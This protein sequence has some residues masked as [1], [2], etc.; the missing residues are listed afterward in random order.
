MTALLV[1]KRLRRA[2]CS[3]DKLAMPGGL[4]VYIEEPN[5][6]ALTGDSV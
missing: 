1:V 3:R 5:R 6:F 4:T 2:Y